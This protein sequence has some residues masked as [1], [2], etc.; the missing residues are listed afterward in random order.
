M[1][2]FS[3]YRPEVK[4]KQNL[5]RRP[6]ANIGTTKRLHFKAWLFSKVGPLISSLLD[7]EYSRRDIAVLVDTNQLGK[8][9][10]ASLVDYN[11]SLEQGAK[12]I[13]FI[14]EESLL[15]SSSEA[16]GI[17]IS[18]LEKNGGRLHSP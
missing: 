18:V 12:K 11:S 8:D 16:V 1:W 13:E 14:S 9:V 6:K 10:I 15:V 3:F 17:I 2:R 4:S 5:R 7:R